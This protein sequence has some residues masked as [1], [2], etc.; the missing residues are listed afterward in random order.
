MS[1]R[2]NLYNVTAAICVAI[3]EN[4]SVKDIA[5]GLADFKGVGRRY[6]LAITYF[7]SGILFLL[8]WFNHKNYFVFLSAL[9]KCCIKMIL[10]FLYTFTPELY[11][12][13]IRV[14]GMGFCTS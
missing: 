2:H 14:T 9:S 8:I 6:S 7:V 1:G 10:T 4:I 5:K 11:G 13:K 3:E 12:T